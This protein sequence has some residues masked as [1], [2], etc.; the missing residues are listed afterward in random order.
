MFERMKEFLATRLV[1]RPPPTRAHSSGSF[2]PATP[3]A[4]RAS[5]S[6]NT[7]AKR[8]GSA[9]RDPSLRMSKLQAS[10]SEHPL[11]FWILL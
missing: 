4:N 1:D 10:R 3:I 7:T 9:A 6:P 2:G 5:E 8:N 11:L